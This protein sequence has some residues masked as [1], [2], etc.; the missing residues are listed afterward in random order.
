MKYQGS[1]RRIAKEILAIMLKDRKPNQWF[2][3]AFAG[4][5]NLIEH[6]DGNRIAND[7]NRFVIALFKAAQ[8]GYVPPAEISE[9]LYY[10]IKRN[11][12]SYPPELVGFV[13]ITCA[14]GSAWFTGYAKD[15]GGRN[16]A[17]EGR[18]NL[19]KQ[20]DN[21]KGCIMVSGE[22]SSIKIP[23]NSI[24]YCDPPYS[25]ATYWYTKGVKQDDGYQIQAVPDFDHDKFWNWCRQMTTKGHKVY[26]SEYTAPSDFRCIWSKEQIENINNIDK[27]KSNKIERL[28]I[29]EI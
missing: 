2:V 26:V 5:M 8:N 22:Y 27:E 10:D 14:F 1:K 28:F 11:Q 19:L 12:L 29:Y 9:E 7:A 16:Y 15:S 24:I 3:D 4:G 20:I 6:V 18:R 21:L 17:S 23:E 13:G 25:G